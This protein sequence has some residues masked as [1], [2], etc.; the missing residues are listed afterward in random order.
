[1]EEGITELKNLSLDRINRLEKE[2]IVILL[3]I[4]PMEIHGNHLPIG[5]DILWSEVQMKIINELLNNKGYSCIQYPVIPLGA[6]VMYAN[7]GYS[8]G[9]FTIKKILNNTIDIL[10]SLGF[11]TIVICNAHGGPFHL[12]AIASAIEH[13]NRHGIKCFST[14]HSFIE[15]GLKEDFKLNGVKLSKDLHAGFIETSVALLEY[16]QLV[17]KNYKEYS[18]PR[19]K[20]L[21]YEKFMVNTLQVLWRIFKNDSMNWYFKDLVNWY[22]EKKFVNYLGYP[23]KASKDYGKEINDFTRECFVKDI[24]SKI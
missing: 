2:K 15:N 1:M 7:K 24:V 23:D 9:F 11:K 17:E 8:Q 10:D 3:P 13:A 4:S 22:F 14:L 18:Y 21:W 6:H 20:Y 12:L 19:L 16:P 5:Q